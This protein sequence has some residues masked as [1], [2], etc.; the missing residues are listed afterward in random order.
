ML[1]GFSREAREDGVKGRTTRAGAGPES[2]PSR[3]GQDLSWT[4]TTDPGSQRDTWARRRVRK[5]SCVLSRSYLSCSVG[6]SRLLWPR[7]S[8][9]TF[10]PSTS[11]RQSVP[12]SDKQPVLAWSRIW[13]AVFVNYQRCPSASTSSSPLHARLA[14]NPWRQLLHRSS[15][16]WV[17]TPPHRRRWTPA[18]A[19][20]RSVLSVGRRSPSRRASSRRTEA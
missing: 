8:A 15:L 7:A 19:V 16:D 20:G 6:R 14:P 17:L 10:L 4:P 2:F 11:P 5:E 1:C 12:P 13:V 18:R 3:D 9:V